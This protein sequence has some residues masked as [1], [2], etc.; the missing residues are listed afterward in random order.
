[1]GP[2]DRSETAWNR[3][4]P[5]LFAVQCRQRPQAVAVSYGGDG[6]TYAALDV[7]SDR[8]ANWLVEHGVGLDDI[9]A[10]RLDRGPELVPVL[11]GIAKAGAAYLALDA[12]M[13]DARRDQLI[14]VAEPVALIA[15]DT[16]G[17]SAS[18]ARLPVLRLPGEAAGLDET[19]PAPV[20]GL[21]PD[22]LAYVSFTSGST[23][24][25][26]GVSVPHRG[27]A[28]LVAG[29]FAEVGPEETF[30]MLSPVAFD[31]STLEIWAC[32]LNGGRLVVHPP[33]PLD[34]LELAAVL[35]RE[36]VTTAYLPTALFHQL[37]QHHPDALSGL[38]QLLAGG[39]ALN[40]LYVDAYLARN[41]RARLINGFGHTE[42]T[43][44]TLTH[45]IRAPV[46]DGTVPV[47]L[48]I[49][50]TRI[51]VLDDEL[52]EVPAG[53]RGDLYVGGAGLS[54]G[55][56]REPAM[57]AL[58]FRPDPFA[59]RPGARMYR[60][61]DLVRRRPDGPYEF[62]G[63][64]DHQL[65]IRGYRVDPREVE[66]Q[67][68]LLP[69]VR[70]AAVVG[71]RDRD[72]GNTLIGYVVLQQHARGSSDDAVADIRRGLRE[73]L[74]GYMI[75]AAFVTL[76]AFP[77]TPNGK[78]DAAALPVPRRGT[79]QADTEYTEP[80][81]PTEQML[82][83]LWAEALEL[84]RVGA[85]DDILDLG[86]GSLLLI[87]LAARIEAVFA[88]DLPGHALYEH[89]TVEELAGLLDRLTAARREGANHRAT[90]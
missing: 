43:T 34:A 17:L 56:L 52:A 13:P 21:G 26:K 80:V 66:Q 4:I 9:V 79:R 28:R 29:R 70:H 81:T 10:V 15:A 44:F 19:P 74:P 6:L 77:L 72:S 25:P 51:M 57:T 3:T 2:D 8:I 45:T 46:R 33:G 82:C 69:R 49:D 41:P 65:K 42:N 60:T 50:G 35:A 39:E 61:G 88:V 36:Q 24:R 63:R 75:P 76:D 64:S 7:A 48:P 27:V 14:A 78:V 12:D 85:A 86:G 58:A 30:L 38:R 90:D 68:S 53:E 83:D 71:R 84:D 22:G 32:L 73:R 47:G 16:T 37:V 40:P 11:L 67:L 5:D 55:Y 54:R 59:D 31:A 20:R 87:E 18:Q 1:M 23:G 62:L 89:P